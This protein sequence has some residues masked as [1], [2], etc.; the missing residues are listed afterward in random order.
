MKLD[1]PRSFMKEQ[2]FMNLS[3]KNMSFEDVFNHIVRFMEMDPQGNY[4]LIVGT[5]SQVHKFH[6][7]FVT[8]IVIKREGKGAW[9]CILPVKFPKKFLNLHEK[10]SME[11]TLTEQVALLFDD[12]RKNELI[13]IVLPHL[14]RGSSFSI[15]G[16]IDVG[17]EK[18]SLSRFLANEM[19]ARIESAGLEP[20]VKPESFVA[21]GY[22]NRY[23][24]QPKRFLKYE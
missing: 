7:I 20:V 14:Y 16:H 18:R 22:A 8:G 21:S 5:D 13:D 17:L 15:E 9:A 10:I 19:M 11:T 4:R 24:K 23:T 1:P 2:A 3:K 6:T 12:E